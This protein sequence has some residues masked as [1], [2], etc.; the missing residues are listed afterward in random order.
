MKQ[1]HT[2]KKAEV[3]VKRMY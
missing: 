3:C 1:K 2:Q